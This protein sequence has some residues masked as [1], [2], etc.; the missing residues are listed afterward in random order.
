MGVLSTASIIVL[1][2]RVHDTTRELATDRLNKL[3]LSLASVVFQWLGWTVGLAESRHAAHFRRAYVPPTAAA[4][5][6][7]RA[8]EMTL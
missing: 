2:L 4:R 7:S 8:L 1:V 6:R 3:R 5:M